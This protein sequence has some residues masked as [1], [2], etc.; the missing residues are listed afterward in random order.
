MLFLIILLPLH[1]NVYEA[2]VVNVSTTNVTQCGDQECLHYALCTNDGKACRCRHGYQGDRCQNDVNECEMGAPCYHRGYCENTFGNWSCDCLEGWKNG[3]DVHCEVKTNQDIRF[4]KCVPEWMGD[5]CQ[6]QCLNDS[7]CGQN[8]I[9][10]KRGRGLRC[11]CKNGWEGDKCTVDEDECKKS[12]CKSFEVCINTVGSFTCTCQ[13]GRQGSRCTDD[14]NECLGN[15]CN[16]AGTCTNTDGSYFCYCTDGWNG[17]NCDK[18][19]DECINQPC[20]DTLVCYNTPGSFSC[21]VSPNLEKGLK[22]TTVIVVASLGALLLFITFIL[23]TAKSKCRGNHAQRRGR[24]AVQPEDHTTPE[25]KSNV[26][27]AQQSKP[28]AKRKV[29]DF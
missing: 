7:M 14:I 25:Q 19:V 23:I 28:D 8:Q 12:P 17:I 29:L 26:S 20:N 18:D 22:S 9:C 1:I 2:V 6:D 5:M 3:V 27:V 13:A 24:T 16:N 4:R 10:R 11:L 15:P 21:D